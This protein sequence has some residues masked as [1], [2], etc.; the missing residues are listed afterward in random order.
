[1]DQIC[2]TPTCAD[3]LGVPISLYLWCQSVVS[4]SKHSTVYTQAPCGITSQII[5]LSRKTLAGI[6]GE[7][8][9]QGVGPTHCIHMNQSTTFGPG[10]MGCSLVLLCMLS[11]CYFEILISTSLGDFT[12]FPYILDIL[13]SSYFMII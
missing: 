13:M 11:F 7:S 10:T 4:Y 8:W 3:L 2:S 9:P 5:F 6:L 12:L 1:M